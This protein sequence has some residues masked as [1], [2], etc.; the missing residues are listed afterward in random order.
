MGAAAAVAAKDLRQRWRDRSA[1]LT[2]VV[3]PLVLAF[4]ISLA[5][6][7]SGV[8]FRASYAV[9]DLDGGAA[10][11]A[12][13]EDVLGGEQLR[14][15]VTVRRSTSVAEAE[16]LARDGEVAAAIIVPAGF[17]ASLSGVEPATITVVRSANEPL[18]ADVAESIVRGFLA[19]LGAVRVSV[20]AAGSALGA[21]DPAVYA[22]LAATAATQPVPVSFEERPAGRLDVSPGSAFAPA[23]GIFFLYYVAG[24]GAR[25][26]V[27]ERQQGTLA[28]LL[29]APVPS[30]R[31][32]GGKALATLVLCVSTLSVMAVASTV[33]LDADWGP[34]PGAVALILAT[35]FAVTAITA[36]VLTVARTQQQVALAMSVVTFGAALLGGNFVRLAYAPAWI[37]RL[38]L[39]TP[40]GWALRAFDDLAAGERG[41]AV[42]LPPLAALCTFGL[43]AGGLAAARSS[44]LVEP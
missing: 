14:E 6:G 22:R 44:R 26:M 21:T 27:A 7:R 24:L 8:D 39:V 3:T 30:R 29:A 16:Q 13:V 9:V 12:L 11:T 4:L 36:L 42:V 23:M 34:L 1:L 2:G 43:V 18:G 35:C 20:A 33:L 17:T 37:Q 41:L 28:R 5:F 25:G 38:S 10:A 19:R 15:I 32:L 31:L 40:N